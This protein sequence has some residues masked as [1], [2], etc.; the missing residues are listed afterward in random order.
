MGRRGE[1]DCAQGTLTRLDAE[2]A[3]LGL[4]SARGSE[5]QKLS[6]AIAPADLADQRDIGSDMSSGAAPG[7]EVA[8]PLLAHVETALSDVRTETLISYRTEP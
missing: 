2:L 4:V 1:T 7:E 5:V 3:D 8:P 6:R